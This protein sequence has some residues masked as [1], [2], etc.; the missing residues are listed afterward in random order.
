MTVGTD[1]FLHYSA[2]RMDG[3][4]TLQERQKVEFSCRAKR[5]RRRRTLAYLSNR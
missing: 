4:K 2:I 3:C 1:V 5:V